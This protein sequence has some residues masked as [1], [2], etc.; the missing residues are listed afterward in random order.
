MGSVVGTEVISDESIYQSERQDSC[1]FAEDEELGW[2]EYE[3]PWSWVEAGACT[4][5]TAQLP[6][7]FAETGNMPQVDLDQ[8]WRVKILEGLK[9][10][11]P[12]SA[13]FS[14]YQN[15]IDTS[16]W[17][18]SG[19]ARVNLK[20]TAYIDCILQLEWLHTT[21][22]LT[23]LNADGATTMVCLI[24]IIKQLIVTCFTASIQCK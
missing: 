7:W 11:L 2:A 22:S 13:A 24:K 17:A 8:P 12:N 14:S 19:E 20:S 10:R 3:A 4:V 23:I 15:A 18:H 9:A 6:N 21:G 1:I 16:S 5:E